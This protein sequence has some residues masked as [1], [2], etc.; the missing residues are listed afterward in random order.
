[1]KKCIRCSE[2]KPLNEFVKDNRRLN[3]VGSHCSKCVNEIAKIWRDN[4][5]ERARENSR[6]NAS[7]QYAENPLVY[8]LR[9]LKWRKKNPEKISEYNHTYH[10]EH[11]EQAHINQQNRRAM[12]KNSNGKFTNQEWENL[13]KQY[14]FACLRCGKNEPEIKLTPDHVKPLKQGGEN[15]IDNIQPLCHSCN[16]SK[17]AKYID[18]RK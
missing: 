8:Y 12:M 16:S 15:I 11:P 2:T 5:P 7:K 10:K 18:Y 13:K 9:N 17:G 1:M 3:G 14:N 4:N 6:R